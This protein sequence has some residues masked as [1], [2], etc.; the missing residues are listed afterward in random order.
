MNK[1]TG[2]KADHRTAPICR[3][4]SAPGVHVSN[5]QSDSLFPF[6]LPHEWFPVARSIK[7][8]VTLH[9]GPTNSGKTYAALQRLK[10][11]TRGDHH[12]LQRSNL[13][14]CVSAKKW[15]AT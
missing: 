9:V 15:F 10:E 13:D 14:I 3:R 12:A 5:S 1:G 7:R 6:R 11:A 2:V 4:F 8:R